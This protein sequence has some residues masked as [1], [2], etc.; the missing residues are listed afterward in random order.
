MADLEHYRNLYRLDG[1]VVLVAG[2]AGGIGTA[3]CEAVAAH[4]ATVIATSRSSERAEAVAA[5]IREAGGSVEGIGLDPLATATVA[6]AVS[7]I[8]ARFGGIDVLVNCVG[9]HI[10]APAVEY[11]EADWD[12][13]VDLNLKS[14]FFL[15]QAV[16][17]AQLERGG[18]GKHVHISSVR[19][20]LGLRRGYASYCATKGGLNLLIK[21]LATEWGGHGI[22]VNG[23]APTFTRTDLVTRYLED[24]AFYEPLVARIPLG[25]I[26]E[27]GDVA[28]LAVYL[29]APAS[30][31]LNGQIVFLDGGI[32]ASQ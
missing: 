7:E 23:I 20:Q 21:Q 2:G 30:D 13:I 1:R 5:S 16:A 25:R 17:R 27:P 6:P 10:E 29:A 24:P 26:C 28:A 8:A 11:T 15:S 18:G 12:H 22:T 9:G 3:I 19:S 4:G 14:A 32:T 31:F